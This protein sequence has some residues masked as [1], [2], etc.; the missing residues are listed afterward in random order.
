MLRVAMVLLAVFTLELLY[1]ATS[2]H[3]PT[4]G[5]IELWIK[6]ESAQLSNWLSVGR[7]L[8]LMCLASAGLGGTFQLLGFP[9]RQSLNG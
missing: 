5:C 8:V 3:A 6:F 4:C 1:L 2:A 9:R 7:N